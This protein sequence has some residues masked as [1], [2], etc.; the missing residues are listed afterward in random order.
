MM[1]KA[2]MMFDAAGSPEVGRVVMSTAACSG[3]C[4]PN[5]WDF[6]AYAG[7]IVLALGAV[8]LA[9]ATA[10]LLER[11]GRFS[12]RI[13]PLLP[14][15]AIV[16]AIA[17]VGLQFPRPRFEPSTV[18]AGGRDLDQTDP[19]YLQGS[20]A[21]AWTADTQGAS[22]CHLA[23]ALFQAEASVKVQDLVTAVVAQPSQAGDSPP[24]R[25]LPGAPYVLRASSDCD[26]RVTFDP[27][28]ESR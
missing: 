9:Y 23:V 4:N 18:V 16:V 25:D 6:L 15:A 12:P 1:I 24:V 10:R 19:I 7:L 8:G 2:L 27:V 28:P 22:T 14:L 20:Y 17:V 26:W 5:I 11:T 3:P 13:I 21:V